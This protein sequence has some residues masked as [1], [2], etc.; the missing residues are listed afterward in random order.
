LSAVTDD[1]LS[2][3]AKVIGGEETVK[4][5][6]VLK[7]LKEATDDQL[8]SKTEMKLTDIRKIL[9]K[10]YNYSIVQCDRSRDKDTGWFIFRWRLQPDQVEGF[11]NNQK[12]RTLKILKTRLEFEKNND[13][14]YCYTSKCNR[15]TFE[16]AVELVFRCP[17]CG[18]ALQHYD[19]NKLIETLTNKIEQLEKEIAQP[20]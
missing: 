15:M 20:V 3:V 2:K 6:M 12:K 7:E 4:V 11:I 13:F 14:Y 5:V 9:F 18:K 17:V 19:N 10:L 16:D 1:V 8:L